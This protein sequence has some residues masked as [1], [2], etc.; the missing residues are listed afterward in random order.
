MSRKAQSK[1]NIGSEPH[2]RNIIL[3]VCL[4]L[5]VFGNSLSGA[6][7]WDDHLL[8]EKNP[9][10]RTLTNI[11]DLF[12]TALWSFAFVG[13]TTYYRPIQATIHALVYQIN[14]SAPFYYHLMNVVLHSIATVFVYLIGLEISLSTPAALI[15]AAL[16]AVHPVHVEAVAWVAGAGD[17]SC[18]VFYF[19]GLWTLLKFS[20]K[21]DTRWVWVSSACFLGAMLSKEVAIT[22]P[23]VAALMLWMRLRDPRA[24]F[25]EIA[26]LWP[27]G[28]S[29]GAYAALRIYALGFS[30]S[31]PSYVEGSILD[32]ISLAVRCLGQY[33]RYAIFPYP[34][35]A[36]HLVPI[37][38]TDRIGS[39]VIYG[40]VIVAAV[41]SVYGARTV[42]RQA[43]LLFATFIAA[44]GLVLYF[45]AI[46]NGVFFSERY[47]YIPSMPI[48][49]L[50]AGLLVQ[51]GPRRSSVVALGA[52]LIF[53][54]R[55]VD[56]NWIWRNDETL[57]QETLK[58][59]PGV[60]NF[61]SSLGETYLSQNDNGRATES[62]QAALEHSTD[63]RYVQ[64]PYEKYRAHLGLGTAASRAGMFDTAEQHFRTAIEFNP[65]GDGAYAYLGAVLIDKD[66]QAAIGYLEKAMALSAINEVARDYMG[67]ALTRQKKYD[68][69]IG[70]FQ[71]ALNINPGFTE[72]RQHMELTRKMSG[73]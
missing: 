14:G 58:H 60:V 54:I 42:L 15:A 11:P 20:A 49:L 1:A 24:A 21:R 23:V 59:Q 28:I 55:S 72:A 70:Y 69:A 73:Q 40:L 32:W 56:R 26:K 64:V 3:L 30:T 61:W 19:A 13:S 12:T 9:T 39:T 27:F 7:V 43:P 4:C 41:L 5:L 31:A 71:E 36:Y 52:V 22:F 18:A 48:L 10:I 38:L 25:G 33:I 46:S 68:E 2:F 29:L 63:S 50:I 6:L 47:L 53:S 62:F 57:Y 66:I 65:S 51:L 17:L 67:V 45:R 34:L 8:V 35:S 44:I 37:H 16:F